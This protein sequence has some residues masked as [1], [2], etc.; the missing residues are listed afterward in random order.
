MSVALHIIMLVCLYPVL[1]IIYF[2]LRNEAKPKKNIILGVT[3]PYDARQDESVTDI[4]RSFKK[5]LGFTAL[6]LAI[7]PVGVFFI[8]Y[9]SVVMSYYMTWM[10][11]AIVSPFISYT[12][13]HI[14]LKKLKY[15][16]GWAAGSANRVRIDTKLPYEEQPSDWPLFLPPLI[17]SLLPVC[18]SVYYGQE[19]LFTF[20]YGINAFIMFSFYPLYKLFYRQRSEAIDDDT[21]LSSALTRVRR[22]N[23]RKIWAG[24]SWTTAAYCVLLWLFISN[25]A[26]IIVCTA[27]YTSV[28]LFVLITA[29]FGARKAQEKLTASSGGGELYDSD[30]FWINGMFYYNPNDEHTMINSR[31]GINMTVNFAKPAGKVIMGIAL[32]CLI[33]MPFIGLFMMPSEFTPINIEMDSEKIAVY[34]TSLVY[35]IKVSAMQSAD[36]LDEL[37][38]MTKI[39]GTN[40]PVLLKG[41]FRAAEAGNAELCLNPETPPFIFIKTDGESYI[42]NAPDAEKTQEIY[43]RLKYL[44]IQ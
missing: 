31:T 12:V 28:L 29:E 3:L 5:H 34:H 38:K 8:K 17:I 35:E 39:L 13:Y 30:R 11:A 42:I 21:A 27:V 40:M 14:K 26:G 1:P 15:A 10:L 25:A 23:W 36:L 2:I 22:Y 19:P 43:D 16:N 44:G 20:M 32:I 24:I 6:V 33:A 4:C 7:L 18:Y 37:P 41:K 9:T